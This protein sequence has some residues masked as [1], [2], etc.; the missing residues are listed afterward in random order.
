MYL[1]DFK[2]EYHIPSQETGDSESQ[3]QEGSGEQ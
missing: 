3:R 2:F 1:R